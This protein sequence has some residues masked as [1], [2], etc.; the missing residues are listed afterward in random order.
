MVFWKVDIT[1]EYLNSWD[2]FATNS[3][4]FNFELDRNGHLR[5]VNIEGTFGSN[6]QFLVSQ[7]VGVER[8]SE[9]IGTY[10]DRVSFSSLKV[11]ILGS[12]S[13]MESVSI[14]RSMVEADVWNLNLVNKSE[15]KVKVIVLGLLQNGE[16]N[17]SGSSRVESSSCTN[18]SHD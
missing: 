5:D 7:L 11:K 14:H 9:V 3:L 17:G 16:I 13:N 10:D 4:F 8:S 12:F 6:E 1:V 15:N 2:N 18:E